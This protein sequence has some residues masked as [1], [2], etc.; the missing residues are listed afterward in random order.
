MDIALVRL[1]QAMCRALDGDPVGAAARATQTIVGLP[2]QHR[3]ALI[4]YR[5][6]EVAAKVPEARAVAEVRVLR[7]V[8]ALPAGEK[9]RQ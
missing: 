2:Q 6:R 5:A 9:G 3:S 1:D 7:E 4:I 8:L